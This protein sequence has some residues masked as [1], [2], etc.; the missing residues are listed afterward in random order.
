M[1]LRRRLDLIEIIVLA[2]LGIAAVT[3]FLVRG[4]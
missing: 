3:L 2:L 4:H 1:K